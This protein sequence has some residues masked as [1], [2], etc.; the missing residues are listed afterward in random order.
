MIEITPDTKIYEVLES[1]EG[2]KELFLKLGYKCVDCAVNIEDSLIAAAKYHNADL[3][4]LLKHI[5][6]LSIND[7]KNSTL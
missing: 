3:S 6:E 5:R 7:N 2:A 4:K 1:L